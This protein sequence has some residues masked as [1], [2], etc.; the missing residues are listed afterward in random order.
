MPSRYLVAASAQRARAVAL[1]RGRGKFIANAA[2]FGMRRG[3]GAGGYAGAALLAGYGAYKGIR[4]IKRA[5]ARRVARRK[6]GDNKRRPVKNYVVTDVDTASVNDL[7][8]SSTDIT[9]LPQGTGRAARQNDFALIAGWKIICNLNNR[10]SQPLTIVTLIASPKNYVEGVTNAA[11]LQTEFFRGYGEDR[12]YDWQASLSYMDLVQH[13]INIDK[14]VVLWK[15]VRH[16]GPQRDSGT[17]KPIINNAS[18]SIMN[19][20]VPLK[21][22]LHWESGI[23]GGGSTVEATPVFYIQFAVRQFQA[24]GGTPQDTWSRDLKII[25]FFKDMAL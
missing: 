24:A 22:K 10:S 4:R 9:V 20:Y 17:N 2:R 12:S 8:W 1:S 3:L 13:P 14:W 25:T 23:E 7:T 21:R 5:K 11:Q 6:I 15:D 16:L 19:K 18:M